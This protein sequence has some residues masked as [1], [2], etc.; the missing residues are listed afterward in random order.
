[1]YLSKFIN[2][3]GDKYLKLKKRYSNTQEYGKEYHDTLYP[4]NKIVH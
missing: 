1:M 2:N 4:L 3:I